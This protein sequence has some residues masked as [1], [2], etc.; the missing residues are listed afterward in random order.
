MEQLPF[1]RGC[2]VRVLGDY[3]HSGIAC[4]FFSEDCGTLEVQFDYSWARSKGDSQ[5]QVT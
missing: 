2:G 1:D 5:T 3:R 4:T